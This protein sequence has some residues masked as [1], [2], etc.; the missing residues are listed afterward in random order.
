MDPTPRESLSHNFWK[1]KWIKKAQS[2]LGILNCHSECYFL[3]MGCYHMITN[4]TIYMQRGTTSTVISYIGPEQTKWDLHQESLRA[5]WDKGQSIKKVAKVQKVSY[6]KTFFR[7]NRLS[8]LRIE[9][10]CLLLNSLSFSSTHSSRPHKL[11]PAHY[12]LRFTEKDKHF[13]N[14]RG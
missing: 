11:Q 12:T 10:R 14:T 4:Y 3:H 9:F 6:R 2:P 13:V 5:A 8:M 1:L 7:R